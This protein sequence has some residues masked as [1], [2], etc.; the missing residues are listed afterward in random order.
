[1]QCSV[2]GK[3]TE[4]QD[5]QHTQAVDSGGAFNDHMLMVYVSPEVVFQS[6]LQSPV[7]LIHQG[8]NNRKSFHLERT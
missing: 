2:S 4:T 5:R 3:V 1:M 7:C 8:Q 6:T